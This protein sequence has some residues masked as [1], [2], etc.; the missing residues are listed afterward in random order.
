[1]LSIL[2]VASPLVV[3]PDKPVPATTLVISP[4]PN[5]ESSE[6]FAN[7]CPPLVEPSWTITVDKSVSTVISPTNL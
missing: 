5:A 6:Y 3:P 2:I 1:M 4:S 7:L